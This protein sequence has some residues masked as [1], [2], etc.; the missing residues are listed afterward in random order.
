MINDDDE[1]ADE[2]FRIQKIITIRV[3]S[4]QNL[5]KVEGDEKDVIDPY[6]SVKVHGHPADEQRFKTKVI[7]N[8]GNREFQNI[9]KYFW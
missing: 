9:P 6:V 5:P 2:W 8:N 4:A 1:C 7:S 3:I